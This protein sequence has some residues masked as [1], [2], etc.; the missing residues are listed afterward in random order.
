MPQPLALPPRLMTRLGP[1]P[2]GPIS[3][4]FQCSTATQQTACEAHQHDQFVIFHCPSRR[5]TNHDSSIQRAMAILPATQLVHVPIQ[6]P[7]AQVPRRI[8]ESR[9][10]IAKSM[11]RLFHQKCSKYASCVSGVGRTLASGNIQTS[12][13]TEKKR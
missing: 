8:N 11:D 10:M 7:S 2:P 5:R 12:Q 6:E 3:Y 9:P 4:P 13:S 1:P